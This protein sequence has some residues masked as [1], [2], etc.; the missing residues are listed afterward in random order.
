MELNVTPDIKVDVIIDSSEEEFSDEVVVDI[1]SD[2]DASQTSPA[3]LRK[4]KLPAIKYRNQL[5]DAQEN[6]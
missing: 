1:S 5:L 3:R 2:D 4:G 6:I